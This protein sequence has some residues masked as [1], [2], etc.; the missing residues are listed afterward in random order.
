[1]DMAM[2][3]LVNGGAHLA[4]EQV[5]ILATKVL[6]DEMVVHHWRNLPA[7]SALPSR[8]MR[9][10]ILQRPTGTGF[11]SGRTL[12]E[13]KSSFRTYAELIESVE[14]YRKVAT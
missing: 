4:L 11:Y 1:M 12:S 2:T 9:L 7:M 10:P 8:S 6:E 14:D 3:P 13:D 5:S